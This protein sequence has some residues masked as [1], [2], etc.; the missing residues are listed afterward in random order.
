VTSVPLELPLRPSEAAALARI[1]FETVETAGTKPI[2]DDIRNRAAARSA[3]Q[4]LETIRPYFGSLARDPVHR[5][6]FYL[7]VD[8]LEAA[9]LLLHFAP[10]AAPTGSVFPKALLVTRTSDLVVNTIPFGPGD[11]AAVEA[12]AASIDREV[13]PRAI[14]A[15]SALVLPPSAASFDAFRGI[16]KRTGKNL[17]ATEGSYHTALWCAIRAGWREG[18]SA[19]I[20]LDPA[21]PL[22]ALRECPLY[23]RFTVP[24]GDLQRA[25]RLRIAIAQLRSAAKAAKPFDL[26]LSFETAPGPTAPE[27]IAHA[28]EVVRADWIA[29]RLTPGAELGALAEAAVRC[30]TVLSLRGPWPLPPGRVVYKIMERTENLDRIAALLA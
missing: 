28:V 24:A 4:K 2:A 23:T 9:P 5:A 25:A 11:R 6:S 17:A 26:E 15:R 12:F 21:D 16:L 8:G 29:P 10:A 13:Q 7:A 20:E 19:G 3:A 1:V 18:W 22:A 14:G 30:R 27:E